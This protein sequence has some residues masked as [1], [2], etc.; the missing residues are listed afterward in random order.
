MSYST[1]WA[2]IQLRYFISSQQ[3][4][5][6]EI[7][8]VWLSLAFL[9]NVIVKYFSCL[10]MRYHS[11]LIHSVRRPK[12][13]AM[14]TITGASVVELSWEH[15]LWDAEDGAWTQVFCRS[16]DLAAQSR[17]SLSKHNN[18]RV[19]RGSSFSGG[20][21]MSPSRVWCSADTIKLTCSL[22]WQAADTLGSL[23]CWLLFGWQ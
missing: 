8:E 4:E 20:N 15:L 7:S 10:L 5:Q 2:Q 19:K 18:R 12:L 9:R 11:L 3:T 16:A 1:K 22:V 17:S 23:H 6:E 14:T 13:N 21:K